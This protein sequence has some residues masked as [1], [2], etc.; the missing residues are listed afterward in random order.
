MNWLAHMAFA[1]P[2][3]VFIA[4]LLRSLWQD[5]EDLEPVLRIAQSRSLRL[6]TPYLI[7]F[8]I[9]GFSWHGDLGMRLPLACRGLMEFPRTWLRKR[10]QRCAGVFR[11]RNL[12]GCY[13]SHQVSNE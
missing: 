1:L 4:S 6:T 10:S 13:E 2:L 12:H 7:G 9:D 8:A 11:M 3:C 5:V